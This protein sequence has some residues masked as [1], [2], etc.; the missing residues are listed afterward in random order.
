MIK[1]TCLLLFL[2]SITSGIIIAQNTRQ[3][4]VPEPDRTKV[5]AIDE[6]GLRLAIE[7]ATQD[8][9]IDPDTYIVGINDVFTIEVRGAISLLLRGI[10]VNPV[11][12]VVIP[13]I[14]TV[15]VSDLTL[16]EAFDKIKTAVNRNFRSGEIRVSLEL[17][18]PV[19]VHLTG[20]IPNPG[21]ITLPYGTTV[22]MLVVPGLFP[23]NAAMQVQSEQPFEKSRQL[24]NTDYDLRNI[25]I[26][27]KSGNSITAD[28]IAYNL[29]GIVELNPTLQDGDI[30]QINKISRNHATI[31]VSGAVNKHLS[32][33]FNEDDTITRLL[34]VAGGLSVEAV[35]GEVNIIRNSPDGFVST[36]VL[37]NDYDSFKLLPF[38]NVLVPVD[39]SKRR[40]GTVKL[41]GEI[42]TPGYYPITEGSTSLADVLNLAGNVTEMARTHSVRINR[43]SE[44]KSRNLTSAELREQLEKPSELLRTSDQYAEGLEFLRMELSMDLQVVFVDLNDPDAVRNTILIDGDEVV[45]ARDDKTIMLMGQVNKIGYYPLATGQNIESVLQ[46]AGGLSEAADPE[47]IF[48]IKSGTRSWYRPGDTVLESGDIVFVDRIPL[49]DFQSSRLLDVQLAQLEIQGKQL[50]LQKRNSTVQLI[51]A[52]IGTVASIITTYLFI[53]QN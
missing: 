9:A 38:D 15:A 1:K 51:F 22:D 40:T 39:Q 17:A 4:Q 3:I 32:I 23:I 16:T 19:H 49:V 33:P 5:Q 34:R 36:R 13:E 21:K 45:I 25:H 28:L 52:G 41:E 42:N 46:Q 2:F 26:Q 20:N 29:G 12:D 24:I 44:S 31:N 10:P 14:T 50:D 47:R 18:R 43:R 27:R 48:I 6:L 8:T 37:V 11:G 30:I 7:N 53:T 35:P